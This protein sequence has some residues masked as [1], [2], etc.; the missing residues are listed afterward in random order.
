M[1]DIPAI[2]MPTIT[3]RFKARLL[4]QRSLFQR[5]RDPKKHNK[6]QA[7][8]TLVELMIVL[9]IIGVLS[10]IAIPNFTKQ[11]DRARSTSARA[12]VSGDAR[13]CAAAVAAGEI[14][15]FTASVAPDGVTYTAPTCSATAVF[16]ARG[17][18][19]TWT[20]TLANGIPRAAVK[21]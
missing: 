3:S 20:I 21:S 8:F 7:G 14:G 12:L 19:D 1:C 18:S 15:D 4:V 5:L 13:A 17:G 2:Q 16:T 10:A 11:A 6:L 9:V